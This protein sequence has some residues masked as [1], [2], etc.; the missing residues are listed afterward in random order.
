MNSPQKK[1]RV[2]RN[3]SVEASSGEEEGAMETS[4]VR[5]HGQATP[6]VTSS[7]AKA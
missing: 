4:Q 7:K 1:K 2:K 5:A 3:L 6:Q